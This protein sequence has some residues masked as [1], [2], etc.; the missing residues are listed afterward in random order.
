MTPLSIET[1]N[2]TFHALETGRGPLALCLH[3]FP[4]DARSWRHQVPALVE[5][6]YRVVTPFMRGYAPTSQ[7]GD[8]RF[9]ALALGEDVA[10][11]LEALNADDA[12]VI[13][14]DW[15]AAATYFGA[16][17]AS[18]RM[19]KIVTLAVP[20]GPGFFRAL[21]ESYA[22]QRRSWY[23]LFFQHAL[24]DEALARDDFAMIEHLYRDWSPSWTPP[25]EALDAVKETLRR[26]GTLQAALGYYR[27]TM[28]PVFD[29]PAQLDGML[30]AMGVP[31]QVPA[32]YLHG[33]EDGCIG[34]ELAQGLEPYFA[35]GVRV[36]MVPGAGHFLHQERPEV[37]TRAI[38]D[39]LA[40]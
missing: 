3:G 37:V 33:A 13:G 28:R 25:R 31:L 5:A 6:G 29:D 26:P 34:A 1:P 15:G 35:R 21:R 16:L 8:G 4:D 19:R 11:L 10:A 23:M 17:L 36:E 18:Q 2:V 14:H 9:D 24:A 7:P 38:L 40:S 30:Q 20:Y 22:Q 32:L 39:F 27:Q 12:V